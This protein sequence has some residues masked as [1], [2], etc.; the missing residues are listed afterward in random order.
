M[1]NGQWKIESTAGWTL[2]E[3]MWTRRGGRGKGRGGSGHLRDGLR[4][5]LSDLSPASIGADRQ[6]GPSTTRRT[7]SILPICSARSKLAQQIMSAAL[8][9][10]IADQAFKSTQNKQRTAM[11]FDSSPSPIDWAIQHLY[12]VRVERSSRPY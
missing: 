2:G 12:C 10:N 11:P 8:R 6:M 1:R 7:P 4:L 5:L 9:D 3:Y